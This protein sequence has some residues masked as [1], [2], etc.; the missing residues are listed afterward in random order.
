MNFHH[1]LWI[2]ILGKCLWISPQAVRKE[3]ENVMSLNKSV[4]ITGPSLEKTTRHHPEN[5]KSHWSYN[6]LLISKL[7]FNS[8]KLIRIPILF[9]CL[10]HNYFRTTEFSKSDEISHLRKAV[11]AVT[12]HNKRCRRERIVERFRR[13]A[14]CGLYPDLYWPTVWFII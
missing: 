7:R 3:V 14:P 11:T 12:Q 8:A 13:S 5:N 1:A 10:S 2:R 6:E 9:N 4:F